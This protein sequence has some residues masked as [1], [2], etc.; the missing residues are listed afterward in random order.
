M[1]AEKPTAETPTKM[2]KPSSS[3]SLPFDSFKSKKILRSTSK[4]TSSDE[5]QS[6]LPNTPKPMRIRSRNRGI[7]YT[8]NQVKK[9]AQKLNKSPQKQRS[10]PL[11][12]IESSTPSKSMKKKVKDTIKLPERY[13][14]MT[15]FF[16]YMQHTIRLLKLKG[17]M[18][19]FTNISPSVES[20]S[21]RRF[22]YT[23][24]AQMKYI[25]PEG[26][27]LRKVT[28]VDELTRCTRSDIEVSLLTNAIKD[29]GKGKA[30]SGCCNL[31]KVFHNRVREFVQTHPEGDDIPMGELPEPFNSRIH[32]SIDL[33]LKQK[34]IPSL[35]VHSS[36][37]VLPQQNSVATSH[38]SRSFKTRFVG[39][40]PISESVKTQLL[41]TTLN[42]L[43]Q[44]DEADT[45]AEPSGVV[46]PLP[47]F[48]R[49][50]TIKN[51]SLSDVA[52]VSGTP[53][54]PLE[55]DDKEPQ[56][57]D[58]K[59]CSSK[60]SLQPDGTPAKPIS[61]PARL[62]TITPAMQTPKRCHIIQDDAS[63]PSPNKLL[64]R[65]RR[66][67]QT[68]VKNT[69]SED[70][71]I[72]TESSS[73]NTYLMKLLPEAVRHSI[74]E[75]EN[76][77]YKEQEIAISQAKLRRQMI[78]CLPKL[79]NMIH[80]MFQS[81]KGCVI[82]KEELM[83]KIITSHLDITDRAELEEQLKLLK[84]LVPDW[85]KEIVASSGDSLLRINK[86]SPP[87]LIRRRLT[88]AL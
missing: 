68:P 59:A 44:S 70:D 3:S 4:S 6:F 37:E 85:I 74:M 41:S 55:I 62:M 42:P 51:T 79:F 52:P 26:I 53:P 27:E 86:G 22:E 45:S 16:D 36:S 75:K 57:L 84:E 13:E 64:R 17:T 69:H 82:T 65:P 81:V 66:L 1:E 87:D 10:H 34:C 83:H 49:L 73:S 50:H 30:S 2:T 56:V 40:A 29:E 67:F 35:P 24:L 60:K 8:V 5:I 63:T 54:R 39:K 46:V 18:R 20:L 12:L 31:G 11:D 58:N 71:I 25:L 76:K 14:V 9:E 61:T 77:A 19:S 47:R 15:K 88:E 28:L 48:S 7:A 78:A 43:S 21:E 32:N 38:L 72:E 80:L 23:H 33:S